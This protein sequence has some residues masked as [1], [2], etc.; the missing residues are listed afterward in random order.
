MILI[1]ITYLV[2][3]LH[4]LSSGLKAPCTVPSMGNSAHH[5]LSLIA[6]I[7]WIALGSD[8]AVVT[9]AVLFQGFLLHCRAANVKL[10]VRLV[11]C[12]CQ[13]Q[14]VVFVHGWA[15]NGREDTSTR[16]FED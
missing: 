10:H 2:A 6:M 4:R 13:Q 1:A 12:S 5:S 7:L 14:M 8:S 11:W 15:D 16:T 9:V 3:Y